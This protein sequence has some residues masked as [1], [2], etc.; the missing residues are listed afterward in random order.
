MQIFAKKLIGGEMTDW[1]FH[2]FFI[3]FL[4][5]RACILIS[6]AR[7]ERSIYLFIPT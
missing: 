4:E 6:N 5:G 1:Q 3:L 7:F 2:R